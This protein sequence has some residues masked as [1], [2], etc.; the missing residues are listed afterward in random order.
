MFSTATAQRFLFC[1]FLLFTA[2]WVQAQ[3]ISAPQKL[4][5]EVNAYMKPLIQELDAQMEYY[6]EK[7]PLDSLGLNAVTRYTYSPQNE[8]LQETSVSQ[9]GYSRKVYRNGKEAE[10]THIGGNTVSRK[11]YDEAG[12]LQEERNHYTDRGNEKKETFRYETEKNA[13][14][15]TLISRRYNNGQL[16]RRSVTIIDSSK[17]KTEI[18]SYYFDR[19]EPESKMEI[20]SSPDTKEMLRRTY[21]DFDSYYSVSDY[22]YTPEGLLQRSVDS[23]M[24]GRSE[25]V[26]YYTAKGILEKTESIKNGKT[27]SVCLYEYDSAGH[28]TKESGYSG[29]GARRYAC[30]YEYDERGNKVLYLYYYWR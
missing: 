4:A 25:Y 27:E 9:S 26:K 8:L 29:E 13:T 22:F 21:N 2:M 28:V 19:T 3:S 20:F 30:I 15:D 5:D 12:R 16:D 14:K 17:G 10:Y 18:W 11:V 1:S 24:Y 23:S 7:Y 6:A